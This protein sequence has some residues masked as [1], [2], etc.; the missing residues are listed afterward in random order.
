MNAENPV[1]GLAGVLRSLNCDRA[2]G[3]ALLGV[4][5]LLA[6]PEI[7]GEP[8]RQALSFDRSALAGGEWWRLLT[9]HFVHLDAEH[10][11][12]NGLGVVLMWALFARDYS[13]VALGGYLLR[14]RPRGERGAVVL[15]SRNSTGTSERSGALHG[16][17]T[18][19]T[20][21]HLRRRDLDGWILAVFIIVKLAYEQFAGALPFAGSSEHYRRCAS[22]WRHRR[23]SPRAVPEITAGTAS[24]TESLYFAPMSNSP[25]NLAFVFPGQGSQSVGMLAKLADESPV[26]RATFDE[27]STVAGLRPVDVV[28]RR[29]ARRTQ[30]DRAHPARHA[31]GRHR[32][33]AVVAGTRRALRP[34]SSPATASANSPRSSPRAPSTSPPA[35][36]SCV[37][38]QGRCRK[39][40]R[41]GT[42]SMAALLGLDDADG[43]SRLRGGGAGLG[44]RSRQFQC[45]GAGGHRR[46]KGGGTAR[47]RS[48]KSAWRQARHRIAGERAVAQQ[49][50]EISG[51][52]TRRTARGHRNPH[53]AAFDI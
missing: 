43:R 15:Q 20:I 10:A 7:I 25:N 40:C 6:L 19:G 49:P 45:A 5:A 2:Y 11:F 35:S 42:G 51:R 22:V 38:R 39:R 17:M 36:N 8:A 53:A 29:A 23:C 13:P 48:R 14:F 34:P 28:Q 37:S 26:V 1:S 16:V 33:L 32:H 3:I 18:A 9:A 52:K 44:G 31:R 21:A 30:R 41:I 47:H 50:H 24:E 4:C 27:A 12:L 46:R